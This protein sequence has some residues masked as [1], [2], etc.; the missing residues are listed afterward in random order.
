MTTLVQ[1]LLAW[2]ETN[3]AVTGGTRQGEADVLG[4][5]RSTYRGY[6]SGRPPLPRDQKILHD[7]TGYRFDDPSASTILALPTTASPSD[8]VRGSTRFTHLR[9]DPLFRAELKAWFESDP[10]TKGRFTEAGK[11]LGV[12]DHSARRYILGLQNPTAAQLQRLRSIIRQGQPR[13]LADAYYEW[14]SQRDVDFESGAA[15]LGVH[16]DAL[17]DILAGKRPAT[18]AELT[19]LGQHLDLQD[20]PTGLQKEIAAILDALRA[21]RVPVDALMGSDAESREAL[22]RHLREQR[23]DWPLEALYNM[24]LPDGVFESWRKAHGQ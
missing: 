24:T 9:P 22:R 19:T 11:I 2:S 23:L 15:Q 20:K 6:L 12:S 4:I 14:V 13:N 18:P 5:P 7:L 10:R 16:P 1:H 8:P 21:L 3:K 17:A